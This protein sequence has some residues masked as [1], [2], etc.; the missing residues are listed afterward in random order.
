MV[1]MVRKET[2]ANFKDLLKKKD[3]EIISL[4]NKLRMIEK[5][6]D[7]EISSLKKQVA[8]G[9][10]A[11]NLAQDMAKQE[12]KLANMMLELESTKSELENTQIKYEEA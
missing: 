4:T 2:E 5:K 7:K 1:E 3:K 6:K 9:G 10:G 8:E 11:S 12:E